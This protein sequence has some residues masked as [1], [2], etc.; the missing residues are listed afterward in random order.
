M[1]A[2]MR[3]ADLL[4]SI[5]AILALTACGDSSRKSRSTAAAPGASPA[6]TPAAETTSRPIVSPNNSVRRARPDE[7]STGRAPLPSECD[8][9]ACG[10]V[11]VTWLDPGYRFLNTGRRDVALTIWFAAKGEC[12]LSEFSI[13]PSQSSGWGN[14]GFCKPYHVRYK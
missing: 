3:R 13:A 11:T 2:S 9:D 5:A 14:V 7:V 8:G 12:L 10:A 1:S 4:V 6:A